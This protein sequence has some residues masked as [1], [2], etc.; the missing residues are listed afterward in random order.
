MAVL[1]PGSQVDTSVLLFTYLLLF[2]GRCLPR[3]INIYISPYFKTFLT[4]LT[5]RHRVTLVK[6][7]ESKIRNS[8]ES[9][10]RGSNTKA[11]SVGGE[12][13]IK[14]S[15]QRKTWSLGA[16][17]C[18][19]KEVPPQ[20]EYTES[21]GRFKWGAA[22]LAYRGRGKPNRNSSTQMDKDVLKQVCSEQCQTLRTKTLRWH[23]SHQRRR[24]C[25]MANFRSSEAGTHAGFYLWRYNCSVS[26]RLQ[27]R[28]TIN[29]STWRKE[30]SCGLIQ[31]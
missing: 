5:S 20:K 14:G 27:A 23:Q 8:E 16:T 7:S 15:V 13:D 30:V 10:F 22:R 19:D 21:P 17:Q 24:T 3:L 4:S 2:Q 25:Q 12:T 18:K 1:L 29:T 26:G 31:A 9:V 6:H 11:D 28:G